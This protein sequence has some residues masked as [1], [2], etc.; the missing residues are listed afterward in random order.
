MLPANAGPILYSNWGK[1][2]PGAVFQ[3]RKKPVIVQVKEVDGY[4]DGMVVVQQGVMCWL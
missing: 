1:A 2:A 3:P 4:N